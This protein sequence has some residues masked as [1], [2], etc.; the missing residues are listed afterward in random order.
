MQSLGSSVTLIVVVLV[1][2]ACDGATAEQHLANAR[3]SLSDG[4]VRVAVI[5]LKNALQKSP[6]L[7]EARLLLGEAHSRLGDYPSAL[8]E[9]E[10]ALD[11]GLDDE[12]L[13]LGLLRSKVRL[14]RFNEVIGELEG[15]T[16]LSPELAVVLGDA[17]L[18][19]GDLEGAEP[20]YQQ[21]QTTSGGSL[22]L[23]LIAWERGNL[24]RS[25]EL[26]DRAVAQDPQNAEAWLRKGELELSNQRLD[27][28]ADSFAAATELPS[29][30]IPGL[31]GQARVNLVRGDLDA[32]ETAAARIIQLAPEY[33]AGQYLQGLI[34][35][36]RQDVD[37][38]EAAIRNV[39]R[40]VPDHAPSLYLMGAIKYRQ[41][42]LAQAADSLQRY[43]SRD[44]GNESAAKLLASIA[45]DRSDFESVVEALLPFVSTSQDPQ[46][47]AM[48]GSAE[49]QRGQP[50][51][52]TAALE[53][54]VALAPDAAPF[55]NQ[56]ALSLLAAG[57]P[58]RAEAELQSAVEVGGDQFQSDYLLAMLRLRARDWEGAAGA[59]SV[60]VENNPEN[61]VGHHLRGSLAL[62]QGQADRA[63][64]SFEEAIRHDGSFLPAV[65]QLAQLAEQAGDRSRA[66]GYYRTFLG[67]NPDNERALLSLADLEA[68]GGNADAAVENVERAI[69][70]SPDSVPARLGLARLQLA[71]GDL[72]AAS[73]TVDQGLARAPDQADLLLLRAQ[74][75]VA[76]GDADSARRIASTLHSLA[77]GR[78]DAVLLAAVGQLQARVGQG[79][80]ARANLERAL[81]LTDG[82]SAAALR[83]LAAIDLADGRVADARKRV[84]AALAAEGDAPGPDT[85]FLNAEVLL[86]EGRNGEAEA[87][88]EALVQARHRGAVLRRSAMNTQSGEPGRAVSVLED[89]LDHRPGD[90][91]AELLLADAVMQSDQRAA[92][93]RYERLVDTNHPVVLNNLAWLYLEQKDPRALGLARRAA[94]VA[95]NN[96]DV[97][98]TL[99]WVLLHHDETGEAVRVLR[100]S[101]SL[102]PD[103]PSV[104]YH[105]GVALREAGDAAGAKA[106]LTRATQ[107]AS[108]PEADAARK[109]L[110]ELAD[111]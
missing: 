41:G 16:G 96:A 80:L 93:G 9:F 102:N 58:S 27:A 94:E 39:Q 99:G 66:A 49:L 42:Q 33:P 74:I 12:R 21:G 7:A 111:S 50:G 110:S 24:A 91:E 18:E 46:L 77:S 71:G 32:A 62:E 75:D 72:Q 89:W 37:G 107:S 10:R 92:I 78:Q 60:L 106:A 45:F 13:Q 38:A 86:A 44:P 25:V 79:S 43:L 59:I 68:R 81:A 108:F 57:D 1:L 101:V 97:L 11:L 52:A 90:L 104:Q 22:G 82:G 47:L 53:R 14:G 34:R 64:A 70:V 17:Y 98:D 69:A 83:G 51:P 54:A 31:V 85:R 55:R 40:V 65:Q 30:R 76:K 105:L 100:R 20:L 95:P 73:S 109:A 8:K 2:S 84:D 61:P 28:A 15:R 3:A 35:F 26:L 103:N 88:L 67:N 23:G 4:E 87:L 36:E 56:L 6:D 63:R 19:A 5:E 48:Y 29:A